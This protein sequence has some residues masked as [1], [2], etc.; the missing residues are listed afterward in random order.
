M[1][2]VGSVTGVIGIRNKGRGDTQN[3]DIVELQVRFTGIH[4]DST[5]ICD[6]NYP[7]N[8]H[9]HYWTNANDERNIRLE[10]GSVL[11]V[12]NTYQGY[13]VTQVDYSGEK[14]PP[15]YNSDKDFT[16]T[17]KSRTWPIGI[18]WRY[19]SGRKVRTPLDSVSWTEQVYDTVHP[20]NNHRE[21]E[22]GAGEPEITLSTPEV[23]QGK[24][25]R[26]TC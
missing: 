2:D 26:S 20:E 25:T 17:H 21:Y 24:G 13:F 9:K 22:V 10:T 3:S 1:N 19:K 11:E 23:E 15:I 7:E 6:T 5:D 4:S 8:V 14:L 18:L 16:F 12:G